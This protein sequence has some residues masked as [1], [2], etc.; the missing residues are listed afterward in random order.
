MEQN[1]ARLFWLLNAHKEIFPTPEKRVFP[2]KFGVF[3][4]K[5]V[6]GIRNLEN[7]MNVS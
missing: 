2:R 5:G 3:S 7:K 6:W 1:L 4:D